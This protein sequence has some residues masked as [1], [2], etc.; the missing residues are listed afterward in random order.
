ML[1][2]RIKKG[3]RPDLHKIDVT[4]AAGLEDL[5]NLM[6]NCWHA[7]PKKR[8]SFGGKSTYSYISYC[9]SSC[10]FILF[11]KTMA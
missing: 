5:V 1:R 4:K 8:P 9:S 3:D 2:F 11:K 6:K 10:C 7:K